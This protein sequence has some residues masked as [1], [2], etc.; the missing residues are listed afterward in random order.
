[1]NEY[2]DTVDPRIERAFE[3]FLQLEACVI[4]AER[5]EHAEIVH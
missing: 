1:M 4:G 3:R 2:M 5:D